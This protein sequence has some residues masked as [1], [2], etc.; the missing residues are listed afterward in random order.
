MKGKKV[1]T[2]IELLVVIAIIA[3]L[4]SLLLPSLNSA[5]ERAHQI[6]CASNLNQQGKGLMMYLSDSGDYFPYFDRTDN[7]YGAWQ[8]VIWDYIRN[9]NTFV[10]AKDMLKRDAGDYKRLSYAFNTIS[11]ADP[12]DRP[13]GKKITMMRDVSGTFLLTEYFNTRGWVDCWWGGKKYYWVISNNTAYTAHQ[14]S[15]NFLFCDGHV[16]NLLPGGRVTQ[17]ANGYYKI[18]FGPGPFDGKWTI[19]KND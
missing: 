3:I 14:K 10:C 12:T 16:E 9:Y 13:S 17:Q 5:R 15:S 2:L 19:T 1:F 6:N 7:S 11:Y 8:Y 18:N 4:A